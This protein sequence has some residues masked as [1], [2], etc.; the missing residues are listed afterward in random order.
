[1]TLA[2][3]LLAGLRV[4]VRTPAGLRFTIQPR[5]SREFPMVRGYSVFLSGRNKPERS[6]ILSREQVE[7]WAESL[8]DADAER[9]PA[10][11]EGWRNIARSY[12]LAGTEK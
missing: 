10:F 11:D 2:E 3:K 5:S 7:E 4:N 12:G 1:M 8:I 6:P 9:Q